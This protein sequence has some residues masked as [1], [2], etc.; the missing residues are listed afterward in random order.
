[1]RS[2]QA[3]STKLQATTLPLGGRTQGEIIQVVNIKAIIQRQKPKHEH[4][5]LLIRHRETRS[6]TKPLHFHGRCF[7]LMR[8]LVNN[9]IRV[10][11]DFLPRSTPTPYR[12][13]SIFHWRGGGR[14]QM[15]WT[16]EKTSQSIRSIIYPRWK[17]T[18]KIFK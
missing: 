16:R 17:K 12:R 6:F 1:M 10:D 3:S 15:K 13:P 5:T 18:P 11:V 14:P 8:R 4:V 9:Q 7:L 2:T